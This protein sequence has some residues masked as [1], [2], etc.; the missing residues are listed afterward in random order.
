MAEQAPVNVLVVFFSRY[1][2]TESLALATGVGAIQA[3]ANIRLRRVESLTPA[4]VI[5]AD[6]KWAENLTRM[7]M[8]YVVPRDPDPEWADVIV[9]ASPASSPSEIRGYLGALRKR[10][11]FGGKIAL[12]F[13]CGANHSALGSLYENASLAGFTVVPGGYPGSVDVAREL[14]NRVAEMARALKGNAAA[15]GA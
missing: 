6:A 9:F 4:N 13:L 1:G 7:K 2:E 8:D 3:R 5:E 11:G 14:G 15:A 10:G 12:P